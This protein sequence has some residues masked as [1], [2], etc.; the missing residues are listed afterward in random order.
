M[1]SRTLLYRAGIFFVL[2]ALITALA[3]AG[4]PGDSPV[5]EGKP[6]RAGDGTTQPETA[7]ATQ[8]VEST[9]FGSPYGCGVIYLGGGMDIKLAL[10]PKGKFLMGP[11][12]PG[13]TLVAESKSGLR[14]K[15][16]RLLNNSHEV[17]LTKDFYMSIYPITH[18]QY[19]QIM[20]KDKYLKTLKGHTYFSGEEPENSPIMLH[21]RSLLRDRWR[22][23]M[24]SY[25]STAGEFCKRLSEK[26]GNRVRL[27][28]EAEWEYAC[29]AGTSTKFFFG[30]DFKD[31]V[32]YAQVVPKG[33]L[34]TTDKP[35]F[36]PVGQKKPNPWGLYDLHGYGEPCSDFYAPYSKKDQ[37]DPVGPDTGSVGPAAGNIDNSHVRRGGLI[38]GPRSSSVHEGS[39]ARFPVSAG[40]DRL[41]LALTPA[42]MFIRIVVESPLAPAPQGYVGV[43]KFAQLKV[44]KAGDEETDI[45][46]VK[47]AGNAICEGNA[48]PMFDPGTKEVK[49]PPLSIKA[50]TNLQM[51]MPNK[52]RLDKADLE[53][54]IH[55]FFQNAQAGDL[56]K[57]KFEVA[58]GQTIAD[59][60]S[61]EPYKM[62]LGEDQ[63]GVYV[64]QRTSRVGIVLEGA[65]R[66]V[67]VVSKFLEETTLA[68]MDVDIL[69]AVNKFKPG[70]SVKVKI[71]G[72]TLKSIEP[73]T[74]A[75]SAAKT[76]GK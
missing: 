8:P 5:R 63:P 64:F 15:H 17:T 12:D 62:A 36:H 7:P 60:I 73:Y 39:R 16:G 3:T 76:A 57:I 61:A 34:F 69:A 72:K 9:Q 33:I 38:L 24:L 74:P 56:M 6:R 66:P 19:M 21:Y 51:A 32:Q 54:E 11:S 42:W 25:W 14:D 67:V 26:T 10:I 37:I 27:P 23:P 52:L 40:D 18:G 48:L 49:S 71:A 41:T 50:G 44:S 35:L 28:T 43:F 29:R 70:A 1:R 31:L 65:E 45:A 58:S 22:L 53:D 2:G 46:Q 59:L 68:I 20:G 47:A 55:K 75:S 30:D 13:E 4:E